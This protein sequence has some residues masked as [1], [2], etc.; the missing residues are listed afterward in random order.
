MALISRNY[1]VLSFIRIQKNKNIY[2]K[3]TPL[4]TSLAGAESHTSVN[5]V[6]FLSLL[7]LK[8]N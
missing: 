4:N 5:V 8:L 3:N 6:S 1:L 2:T 7:G